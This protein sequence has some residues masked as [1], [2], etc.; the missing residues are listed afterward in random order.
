MVN[1]IFK[2]VPIDYSVGDD[3][4]YPGDDYVVAKR[5]DFKW[6]PYSASYKLKSSCE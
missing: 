2:Q 4:I 1:T 5:S 3:I 6:D